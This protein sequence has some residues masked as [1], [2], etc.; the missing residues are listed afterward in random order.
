MHF[1]KT[2]RMLKLSIGRRSYISE[3]NTLLVHTYDF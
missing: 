3:D 1:P 2:A